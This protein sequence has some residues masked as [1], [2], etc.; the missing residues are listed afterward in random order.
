MPKPVIYLHNTHGVLDTL[1]PELRNQIR[2]VLSYEIPRAEFAMKHRPG[3]DGRKYFLK[4]N[5]H[6]LLGLYPR[7]HKWLRGQK[8]EFET[9]DMRERPKKTE[10][11]VLD[12]PPNVTPR[13]YQKNALDIARERPRGVFVIGTGG[14]KSLTAGL[15][16]ANHEVKTLVVTPNIDLK[17]QLLHTLG[18]LFPGQVGTDISATPIVVSN[19][20]ALVRIDQREFQ[21]FSMLMIDEFHHAAADSYQLISEYCTDAFFRYGFTGTFTRSNGAEMEMHG[22]LSEVI[23]RKTTSELI[24]E[25]YLARPTIH[26]YHHHIKGF[27]SKKYVDAYERLTTDK[28]LNAKIAEISS[29]RILNGKQVLVL[30]RQIEHGHILEKL[31]PNAIF[32]HGNQPIL[33][34]ETQ[35]KLF[36]DKTI[37][38]IIASEIFGE[39]TD[40][41]SIDV[42]INAR[43]QKTEIQTKQGIGRA[44]RK[45]DTKITAEVHDFIVTGNKHVQAH[46]VNR[47]DSYKSEP[48][49]ILQAERLM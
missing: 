19:I 2:T 22:V 34:R 47:M 11:F 31:I 17:N 1:D 14:G 39:G 3:W 13:D 15:I 26:I 18:I 48:A 42:L 7:L 6:F 46:S 49:F 32:L 20:Q 38:C 9:I 40:I 41:P 29:T 43:Y 5:N 35:K 21:R 37:P 12:F 23:F 45:T 4:N 33:Y 24:E 25:G 27:V 44:L 30:V 8:V 10:R 36:N 28:N 16:I